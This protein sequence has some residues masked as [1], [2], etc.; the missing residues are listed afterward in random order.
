MIHCRRSS[1]GS[2]DGRRR[3]GRPRKSGNERQHQGMDGPVDVFIAPRC[4]GQTSMGGHHSGGICRGYRNDAWASRVL[5]DLLTFRY[6]FECVFPSE[7]LRIE[8]KFY[9]FYFACMHILFTSVLTR[10]PTNWWGSAKRDVTRPT[11]TV[12]YNACYRNA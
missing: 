3:R 9:M 5:I 1:L 7:K 12:V 10:R 4:R 11:A 6:N 2:V 8:M